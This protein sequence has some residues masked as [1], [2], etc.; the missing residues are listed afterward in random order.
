MR[1]AWP[2]TGRSNEMQLIADAMWHDPGPHIPERHFVGTS[3]NP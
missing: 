3:G 1:F 2:L